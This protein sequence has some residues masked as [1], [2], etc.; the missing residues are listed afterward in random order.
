VL[1]DLPEVPGVDHQIVE[2]SRL[3]MHVAQAGDAGP[4]LILLHGWPEHWYAW[5]HVIPLFAARY[6]V[7]CPDLRGLGWTEAPSRG[8]EKESLASDVL[9]LLDAL[10]LPRVYLIGHDWGAYAGF[11]LCLRE[12][13]RVERFVA[14]NDVHPWLRPSPKD[15]LHGWRLWYQWVLAT[16]AVG[17]WLLENRPG[18]VKGLIRAWSAKDVW[19]ENDLDV[20]ANSLRDPQR[21]RASA[22]YYRTF[23]LRELL[24]T[25]AGRYRHSRLR[26]P[27]LFLF[28][29]DDG[30]IRPHQLRGYENH[31]D[32]MRLELIPGVGHF[33][34]E[35]A[36]ELVVDRVIKHFESAA[37]AAHAEPRGSGTADANILFET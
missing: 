14:L 29:A 28:G 1:H 25:L 24:P 34:P 35:E 27:T 22:Q 7:F 6:R 11:L 16:P 8:Y 32:N 12:P 10:E 20:F 37:T 3:R 26:T 33:T 30:V 5:R 36:P 21:A 13:A 2:T 18:F 23:V 31:A 19:S 9:A 15:V 17:A 4:P